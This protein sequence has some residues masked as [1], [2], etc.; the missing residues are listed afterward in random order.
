L[1]GNWSLQGEELE[2]DEGDESEGPFSC[3][4]LVFFLQAWERN[5]NEE[6]GLL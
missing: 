4:Y 3:N 5:G 6:E 2:E 1:E